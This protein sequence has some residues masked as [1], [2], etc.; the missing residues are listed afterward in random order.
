MARSNVRPLFEDVPTQATLP[1][2]GKRSVWLNAL[3]EYW[4]AETGQRLLWAPVLWAAGAGLYFALTFEP[5]IAV[6]I[7]I[8]TALLIAGLF[9]QKSRLAFIAMGLMVLGFC[10]AQWKAQALHQPLISQQTKP[11]SLF[12]TVHKAEK[13]VEGG[14]RLHLHD[15]ASP[16]TA[17]ALPRKVRLMVRTKMPPKLEVGQ[18]VSLRAILTPLPRPV[19]AGGYEFGRKL[20][21]DGYGATGFAIS[22][23]SKMGKVDDSSAIA[24]ARGR[25]DAAIDAALSGS[26]AGL[27][28]ALLLGQKA[29]IPFDVRDAYRQAGLA[30][31]LAISGLHMALVAGFIFFIVR[32]GLA[33]SS[34][35][36]LS[37]PLKSYAAALTILALIGYLA[38]V[39]API[40]AQR[41]TIMAVCVM[42]AIIAGRTAISLRTAA[43]AAMALL[44]FWPENIADIGFQMSFAAV[45]ALISSY[46]ATKNF[47]TGLKLRFPGALGL[48]AVYVSGIF[49]STIV[50]EIAVF[51][52]SVYHFNEITVYGLAGNAF[53]V[54]ITGFWIM[55]MGITGVLLTPFGLSEVP[56]MAMG[57][58][59]DLVTAM[60][61]DIAAAPG[62]Y[63]PMQSPS[64]LMVVLFFAGG[65]WLCLWKTRIRLAGVVVMCLAPFL[66]YRA[67]DPTV[68]IS[69]SGS[70]IVV[71]NTQGGYV[72]L[73]GRAKGFAATLWARQLGLSSFTA[74]AD[75]YQRC[76]RLGCSTG[77]WPTA[78][79]RLAA[80]PLAEAD[81]EAPPYRLE[82]VRHPMALRD[83]CRSNAIVI[84]AV[85]TADEC[86]GAAIALRK[87]ILMEQGPL[88]LQL[89]LKQPDAGHLDDGSVVTGA[90]EVAANKALKTEMKYSLYEKSSPKMSGPLLPMHAIIQKG[91]E[92]KRPWHPRLPDPE[93][94]NTKQ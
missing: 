54:P 28:K 23:V 43:L 51:P 22:P 15:I 38:L 72:R 25:V 32:R 83:A 41:A 79:G 10:T 42:L 84:I 74:E 63:V 26:T 11:I 36:A 93:K 71:Q 9:L 1:G 68:L 60:T 88:T 92:P 13:R 76:D 34:Y 91:F 46:E 39:G 20:F 24:N 94:P 4:Q 75:K 16:G 27:A 58:G 70:N 17:A 89:Y 47:R 6:G 80:R 14:W 78:N 85:Q 87:Q 49:L 59:I 29:E 69:P 33:L 3:L 7:F 66:A 21:L 82:Y 37:L 56:F 73:R 44:V 77:L 62:A 8:V 50:A 45:I 52:L 48:T 40:S 81:Q 64:T 2:G 61:Q 30:H 18:R 55:P 57:W 67:P 12:A 53:A 19:S 86:A 90:K 5:P 35:L 65:L 31:L